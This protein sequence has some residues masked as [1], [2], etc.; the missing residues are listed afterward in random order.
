MKIILN[1]GWR[2][3]LLIDLSGAELE[4]LTRILA[5]G[6]P[7]EERYSSTRGS[8]LTVPTGKPVETKLEFANHPIVVRE[9]FDRLM[10]EEAR[11]ISHQQDPV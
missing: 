8:Y 2:E 7:V 5:K 10:D 3:S 4:V 1:S 6:Q 11:A 9:E